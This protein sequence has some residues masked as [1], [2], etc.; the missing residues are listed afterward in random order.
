MNER[1][2]PNLAIYRGVS[3]H[4]REQRRTYKLYQAV[5]LGSGLL[6]QGYEDLTVVFAQEKKV[7]SWVSWFPAS[8]SRAQWLSVKIWRHQLFAVN[9]W[10]WESP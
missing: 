10:G 7:W 3:K 9:I 2:Y 8:I 6:N 4:S 5:D 1:V